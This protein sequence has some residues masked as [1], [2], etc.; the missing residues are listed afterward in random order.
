MQNNHPNYVLAGIDGSTLSTAVCDYA[1]WVAS[2][3]GAPLK[4]LHNLEMR[5]TPMLADLSGSIGLGS[6]AE[7]LEELTRVEQER[8]R[9]M[10][11]KGKLMLAAARQRAE[12]DGVSDIDCW[13]RHGN[14]Q[15]S[16]VE[17]EDQIRVMVMGVRGEEHADGQ[18]GSHLASVIRALHKPML[19]V[20][21]DFVEPQ[22]IMLAYD[23]QEAS[24]K[25]LQMVAGSSL[26]KSLPCHLVYVGEAA[27]A[28]G[29]LNEASAELTTS[30]VNF[31]AVQLHGPTDAALCEYQQQNSID[32]TVMGA[33]S[34]NR[35]RDMLLGSFTTKMLNKTRQPLL[36]LR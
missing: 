32:L 4:L 5:P 20:N 25:A 29:I 35:L 17:L 19:V 15:E 7:L 10:M 27:Q 31:E 22:K 12:E 34:H 11:E 3:L 21:H 1:A 14:L 9:L 24:K 8:A 16:L 26:L 28:E 36:L 23:G 13:Q 2:S 6:Q 33:F 18:L 30:G